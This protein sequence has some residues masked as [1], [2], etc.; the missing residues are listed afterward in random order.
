MDTTDEPAHRKS[1]TKT[2]PARSTATRRQNWKVRRTDLPIIISVLALAISLFAYVDQY[3]ANRIAVAS[4][5]DMYATPVGF[6]LTQ[7]RA[8]HGLPETAVEN[9]GALP[10]SDVQVVALA[11][12]SFSSV[13]RYYFTVTFDEGTLAPCSIYTVPAFQLAAAKL[14]SRRY[15]FNPRTHLNFVIE[16]LNFTDS[17]GLSWKRSP[18]GSLTRVANEASKGL[19]LPVQSNDVSRAP[20]CQ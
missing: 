14:A 6:W 13:P 8:P 7:P 12:S 11:T 20:D 10:I 17:S 15:M 19:N 9:G 5:E 3:D 1:D 16:F 18:D 4:A 2:A